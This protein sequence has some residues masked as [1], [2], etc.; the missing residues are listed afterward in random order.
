[1]PLRRDPHKHQVCP[2]GNHHKFL[3]RKINNY[4]WTIEKDTIM[5]TRWPPPETPTTSGGLPPHHQEPLTPKKKHSPHRRARLQRTKA[6]QDPRHQASL[7]KDL[8]LTTRGLQP[9]TPSR[10]VGLP[11]RH[12]DLTITHAATQTIWF[13]IYHSCLL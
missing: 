9:T 7:V 1:M 6:N 8:V 2:R 11:P 4:V 13:G 3:Q 10:S 5:V 12:H